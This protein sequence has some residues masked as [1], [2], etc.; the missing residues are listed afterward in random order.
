MGD[1]SEINRDSAPDAPAEMTPE[2]LAEAREYGRISLVCD[3]ADKA[4]DVAFLAIVALVFAVPLDAFLARWFASDTLRLAAI[5]VAAGLST[6]SS[7]ESPTLRNDGWPAVALGVT[8]ALGAGYAA[9]RAIRL[10]REI[11]RLSQLRPAAPG[12][13]TARW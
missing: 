8:L 7:P 12:A 13:E 9:L 5:F 3:L 11:F 6:L 2:Q 10:K 1:V 4:L